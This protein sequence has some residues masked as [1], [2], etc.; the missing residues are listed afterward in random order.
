[1][2]NPKS[3]K[4]V[5]SLAAALCTVA[6]VSAIRADITNGFST[7]SNWQLNGSKNASNGAVIVPPSI[8]DGDLTLTTAAKGESNS[9]WYTTPQN[10]AN[11]WSAS[12]TWQSSSDSSPSPANGFLFAVQ[13]SGTSALGVGGGGSGLGYENPAA[14][15]GTFTAVTPSVA[16]GFNVYNAP[17]TVSVGINGGFVSQQ[18]LGYASTLNLMT[19]TNP[20]NFSVNYYA[21]TGVLNV[22]AVDS[23]NSA[24]SLNYTY[25]GAPNATHDLLAPQPLNVGTVVGNTGFVGFTGSTGGVFMQQDLTNF[26]FTSNTGASQPPGYAP[27]PAAYVT[28]SRSPVALTAASFNTDV[29][30]ENTASLTEGTAVPANVA[31]P[32]DKTYGLYESG[33]SVTTSSG[34]SFAVPDGLPTSHQFLSQADNA[35]TFQFQ[36]YTNTNNA[37]RLTS[38]SVGDITS[39]TMTLA[40]PSAFGTLAIL[41]NSTNASGNSGTLTLNFANGQTVTTDYAA[42]DWY[43]TSSTGRTPDGNVFGVALKGMGRIDLANATYDSKNINPQLFETVLNLSDLVTS[44]GQTVNVTGDVLD[45]MTFDINP[46]ALTTLIYGVSGSAV[47]EPAS[48]VLL[49]CGAIGL[50]LIPSRMVRKSRRFF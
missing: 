4:N 7:V 15:G 13:G 6:T 29:V 47:P 44:T 26:N 43:T 34:G 21:P 12:F 30:V 9:A 39:G 37:L 32:L 33:L 2:C 28:V 14:S 17:S 46:T 20:I 23:T 3:L 1:M 27:P 50:L 22:S 36:H 25:Y 38:S 42:P 18:I 45:S 41:A 35:T 48:L 11:S 10:I 5:L 31:T 19:D 49:A 16:I 8:A 40:N 24:H